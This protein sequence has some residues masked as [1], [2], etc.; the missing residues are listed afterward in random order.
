MINIFDEEECEEKER[1]ENNGD[2]DVEET[3]S[4]FSADHLV[5]MGV[6]YK[7]KNFIHGIG[8]QNCTVLIK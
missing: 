2:M 4:P 6:V 7:W 1:A 5:K 8:N 3:T